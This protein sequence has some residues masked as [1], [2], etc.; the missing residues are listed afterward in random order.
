[1]TTLFEKIVNGDI[2]SHKVYEDDLVLAFLDVAPLSKGHTL[3]IPKE[4]VAHLHELSEASASALGSA[5]VKVSSAI[6]EATGATDYNVLQNNGVEAH[7]AVN[8]VHFH[9]IPKFGDKG[10]TLEWIP[11]ELAGGETLA[12]EIASK[13]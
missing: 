11:E 3:V 5:L 4:P 7:Q 1:M 8:H 9:I 10:L 2:P 6:V 13:L 12:S